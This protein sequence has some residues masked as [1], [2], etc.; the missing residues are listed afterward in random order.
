VRVD[1]GDTV[2][3]VPASD[4]QIYELLS[5]LRARG[6]DLVAVN[7]VQPDLEEV[8]MRLVHAA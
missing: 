8:F 6:A 2:V 1:A 4:Q 3:T 5:V 7:Q